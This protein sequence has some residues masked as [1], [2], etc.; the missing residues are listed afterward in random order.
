LEI[1]VLGFSPVSNTVMKASAI[2]AP[3]IPWLS[4]YQCA[5][6]LSAPARAKAVILGSQ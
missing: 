6:Q 2:S 5:I 3:L 4:R 1:S